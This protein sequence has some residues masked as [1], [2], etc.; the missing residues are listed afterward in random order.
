M[1]CSSLPTSTN[2]LPQAIAALED[3]LSKQADNTQ[4][5]TVLAQ[6]YEKMKDFPKA[7]DSYERLLKVNPDSPIALNNLAYLYAERLDQLDKAYN[8]AHK[9]KG[10]LPADPS[11]RTPS[12]GSFTKRATTKNRWP[13]FRRVR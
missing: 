1:T 10:L 11:L 4:A 8:L 9:A 7:R 2:R 12:A 13:R 6:T 5:M 3:L